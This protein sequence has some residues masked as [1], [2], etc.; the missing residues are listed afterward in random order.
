MRDLDEYINGVTTLP[1]AP[2]V[3]TEL[4]SLL[5]DEEVDSDQVVTVIGYDP[6]LTASVLQLCNSAVFS[7][8]TPAA[9]LSE[10][11]HR[12]GFNRVY[13]LVAALVGG[14]SLGPPQRGY[15]IDKGELWKHSVAAAVAA[16]GVADELGDPSSVVY[17]A[18]LLHDIGKIVLSEALVEGYTQLLEETEQ[19]Q[20]PLLDTEKKLLGA[21]HAEV[22]GRLLARWQFPAQL[23]DAVT[24]HHAPA[25]GGANARLAA[26]T[27]LGNM[28]AHFMGYGY[29]HV[30]FAVRG[31][32]EAVEI[33]GLDQEALP[34]FMI[35]TFGKIAE[36]EALFAAR[37]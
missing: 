8:A 11:V 6:G 22:G 4:L 23:V 28:L 19:K 31:R 24:H 20:Q 1:P 7:G 30:P 17:T 36:I 16:Q 27:Y 14:K 15:G 21:D 18:A 37:G 10:A 5:A 32:A 34:R 25:Q 12:L 3:L 35:G 26:Y 29:G 9:D 2:R 33:L 13:Q